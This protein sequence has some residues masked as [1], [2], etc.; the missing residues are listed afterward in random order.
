MLQD[1]GLNL[2]FLDE[3]NIVLKL[4]YLSV[5]EVIETLRGAADA[6]RDHHRARR[7]RN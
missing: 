6:A 5:S 4:G 2:V 1:A 7:R 3:L